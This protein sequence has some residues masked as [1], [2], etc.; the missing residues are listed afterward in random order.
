MVTILYSISFDSLI[1]RSGLSM[2]DNDVSVK[3]ILSI[4]SLIKWQYIKYMCFEVH[5]AVYQGPYCV[6]SAEEGLGVVVEF[7]ISYGGFLCH[8]HKMAEGHIDFSHKWHKWLSRQDDMSRI[9]TMTLSQMSRSQSAL[10]VLGF[11]NR[12]RP[13]TSSCI[14]GFEQYLADMI[15]TRQ[16]VACKNH[17]ARSKVKVTIGIWSFCVLESCPTHN[18][19]M[20]GRIS[21]LIGKNDYYFL[22]HIRTMSLGQGHSRHLKFVHSRIVSNP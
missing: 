9:R 22:S 4:R 8:R 3:Q 11:S 20:H 10:K 1:Y 21:K 5:R 14:V 2:L 15:I 19:I 6:W 18:I 17:V 7:A 12:V 16:S 13:I